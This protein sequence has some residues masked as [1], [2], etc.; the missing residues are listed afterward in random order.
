MEFKLLGTVEV[1]VDGVPLPLGGPRQ[2]AVLA[3]LA[4]HVGR[5]VTTS[6]LIDDL[7]GERAPLSA[8]HTIETYVSRIRRILSAAERG[9]AVLV[10]TP[11]GYMLDLKP[12]HVDV[13]RFRD[14]ARRGGDALELGDATAAVALVTSAL[15]LWR[16]PALA[17]IQDAAFAQV[18][19]KGLQDERLLALEKLIEARLR[20]G[21]HRDLVPE[22]ETIIAVSPYHECFHAQLM[23]ALYRSGRQAEALAAFRRARDLLTA[24]LGIEPSRDLRELE[25]AILTQ[26]QELE[27]RSGGA[28]A[29]ALRPVTDRPPAWS[30]FRPPRRLR[31]WRWSAA[32]LTIGLV[33]AV[34]VAIVRSDQSHATQLSDSVGELNAHG[35]DVAH[36]LALPDPPGA[37]VAA[38]GAV[39]V[40]SPEGDAVYRIDPETDAITQTISVGSGPSAITVA[41]KDIWVANTLD[42]TVS[43]TNPA[44]AVDRVVQKIKVGAEPTGIT[45]GGGV[46]WVADASAS[47]L[48]GINPVSGRVIATISLASPPFGVA[49]GGGALWVTS[50]A[51]DTLT[52]VDPRSRQLG[53][54]ITVGSGPTAVAYGNGAVWVANGLDSTISRVNPRTDTVAAISAG[55]GPDA[56]AIVGGSVWA[57]NRLS[58][59]LTRIAPRGNYPAKTVPVGGSPVAVTKVGNRIWFVSDAAGGARPSGGTLRVA[60]S[61][62]PVSIDPALQYPMVGPQFSEA[63]YDTLVTFQKTGGSGGLLLV[64]DLALAM[65][66][67]SE[68]GTAYTFRLRPGLRYSTGQPIRAQDF[69]YALERVLELNA[70]AGSFLD[71]IVG[72]RACTPHTR[73]NLSRGVIVDDANR[74]VTFHLDAPDPYLLDKLAFE[75]TAPVPPSV[76]ARGVPGEPVPGAGPYEVTRYIPHHKVVFSRNPYFHEWSRAAQPEGSPDRIVWRFGTPIRREGAEIAA[77]R[78]DWT[79]DPLPDAQQLGA[80]F[81]G[82]VHVNPAPAIV[83]AAFN[84][85]VAPFDDSRVRRA[86]SL[87]A[88]RR[89]LVTLL[90][91]E[92]LARPTCQM[93]PPGIPGYR[94]YCPFTADASAS[95]TWVG[96]DVRRAK[97]LVAASRTKGMRVTVWS[98]DQFTDPATGAFIV[99]VLDEL[100]YR[101]SLHIASPS[102]L[103]Q[104]VKNSRRRIQAT[105]GSWY[106]DYPSAS[107]FFDVFFRCSASRLDDPAATRNGSF[108][109]DRAADRLM[110]YAGRE[111]SANPVA[112]ARTWQAVDRDVTYAAPWVP[113]VNLNNVDFLSR[114]M[115]N[116]QYN[117]F[118]GVLLDQL[119]I[120][121]KR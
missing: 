6:Q 43:R 90:G 82:R 34:G 17:D 95:G 84:T 97:G 106:F 44:P 69:R 5:A 117:P 93:L 66:A 52:R 94:P 65:P 54:P 14:M 36:R 89:R 75:F 67:V 48:R 27:P 11:N 63:T 7:W 62:P 29:R 37:A 35:S 20:L 15:E 99:S 18:T 77:G 47:T 78:A 108:F 38:D 91:G 87:A 116:Y 19:G 114:R 50:P 105:D 70:Q 55:D 40:T 60:S 109:C 101:A 104:A 2:R 118:F 81:P 46:I 76:P 107:D 58:S 74:T 88:N 21:H 13:C 8:T 22:I 103:Q 85:R 26:A 100:G 72:A 73:C 83:F 49:Y 92:A 28:V 16:G 61:I 31:V 30:G 23:L 119:R 53:Q 45:A 68:G 80:R 96:P 113:L 56:L 4:L 112:A 3:D 79:N 12:E 115:T 121:P 42:G 98:D 24:E 41:D 120:R 32:A 9:S 59:T 111:A 71:G 110:N 102:A 25:R 1:S 51:D 39:W 33:V 86:F 10:T 57:A 64:P